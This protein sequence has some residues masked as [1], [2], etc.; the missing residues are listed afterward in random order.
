MAGAAEYLDCFRR[1]ISWLVRGNQEHSIR[2]KSGSSLF[3]VYTD[4]NSSRVLVQGC[5][6]S[7]EDRLRSRGRLY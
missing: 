6:G 5:E 1:Y 4:T 3:S 7:H 2:G